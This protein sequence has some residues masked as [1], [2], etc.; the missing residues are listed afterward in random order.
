MNFWGFTSPGN[1]VCGPERGTLY[2]GLREC[3]LVPTG[4]FLSRTSFTLFE[5]SLKIA[6]EM[7][8]NHLITVQT[9]VYSL[10]R[11]CDRNVRRYFG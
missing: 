10:L 11:Q 5:A 8:S 9:G 3:E 2:F 1:K 4:C 6:V 7:V